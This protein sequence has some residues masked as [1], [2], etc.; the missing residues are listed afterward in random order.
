MLPKGSESA[1]TVIEPEV[2]DN[3]LRCVDC[4]SDTFYP[5]CA[6]WAVVLAVPDVFC[7]GAAGDVVLAD[8]FWLRAITSGL[9]VTLWDGTELWMLSTTADEML[10]AGPGTNRSSALSWPA[11]KIARDELR[12]LQKQ[13]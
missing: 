13:H 12:L 5:A 11:S 10:G 8:V 1:G 3:K 6:V 9:V 4:L 7:A 2:L